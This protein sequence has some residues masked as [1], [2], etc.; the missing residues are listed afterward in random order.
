MDKL[1]AEMHIDI[2]QKPSGNISLSIRSHRF[3]GTPN[4]EIPPQDL[5]RVTYELT[6]CQNKRIVTIPRHRDVELPCD[7]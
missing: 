2:I 1:L 7:S 3:A 6:K 4:F 5:A